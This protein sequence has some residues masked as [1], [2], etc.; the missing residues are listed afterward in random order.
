MSELKE[1]ISG[2]QTS[3]NKLTSFFSGF[4]SKLDQ[5]KISSNMLKRSFNQMPKITQNVTTNIKN[6][7]TGLKQSLSNVLKYVGALL[8]LRGIYSILSNSAKSWLSSQNEGAQQLSANIEYMKYAMGS[9]FAPVVEYV[10]NLVYQLMKAVQSLV[11]AFSGI[12]IFAKSTAASMGKTAG[13]AKNANESLSGIHN[14]INNVSDKDSSGSN[15]VGPSMDLSQVDTQMN[16]FAQKL[17]DFFK[18]L[19]E[20]WYN[21]GQDLIEQIKTTAGQVGGLIASVWGSFENIITNGTVY[22]ILE[23]ILAIIGNIS[24]AFSNAWNYNGN[25]D[26]II[27]TIADMLNGIFNTIKEISGSEG[28]Q[29]FL[30]GISTGFSGILEFIEPVLSDFLAIAKPIAEIA[31]STIGTVLETIGN[32][33]KVI[34]ENE[35][36]VTI[37][38]SI[39]LAIGLITIATKLFSA[40]K[41]KETGILIANAA[42]WVAANL[43]IILIAAAIAA[44]IAII[45]LCVKHWDE[46]KETVTT[47]CEK[48]KETVSSWVKKIGEFFANLWQGICDIFSGIGQWFL[49][50]FDEAVQGIKN[51][52]SG[53]GNFFLDVWQGI[54][55]VF[56]NVPNWFKD[57]FSK[58]WQAVKNVFSAGGQIFDGIKDGILNGLKVVVN[59][60]IN[61]INKVISI[62]FNR[63]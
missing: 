22:S 34:G 7:G 35:I 44:V 51:A 37:L 26:K 46:I 48:I 63:N 29:T 53:V 43:P 4:K 8:S 54:C 27:Q 38:E 49:D 5:T 36:V 50:K 3:Q 10:I 30:N 55:N 15:S 6:I 14:E 58:A 24:E 62:P 19:K 13:S 40:E 18:P 21:Y 61:G 41:I 42:A 11:Y 23:N 32:T 2:I 33:L 60:I 45:I 25:G 56:E 17:Y 9:A 1:E 12:N 31:L 16:G 52:F 39:A 20:S 28:F 47:V 57:K 59:A